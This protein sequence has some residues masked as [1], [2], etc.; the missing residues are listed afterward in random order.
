MLLPLLKSMDIPVVCHVHDPPPSAPFYKSLYRTIDSLTDFFITISESVSV[1]TSELGIR[2]EKIQMLYNGIDL[3]AFPFV[4][5]RSAIFQEQYDWPFDS[6]VIGITGQILEHK[7]HGDLV[8]AVH[9]ARHNVKLRLVIGGKPDGPYFEKLKK[10]VS[11][12]GLA[13]IV[14]FAGWQPYVADFFA[15]IDIFVLASRHEE[16][17]GL[18][19]AE[20]MATGRPV[21]ATASGGSREVVV[22]QE[23]GLSIEKGSPAELAKAILSLATSIDRRQRMGANGR[24]RV[25]RHFD[26]S[27]Q[28]RR[29]E[30]NLNEVGYSSGKKKH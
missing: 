7:G 3:T 22:D 28:G 20:A 6:V 29:F 14:R 15:G 1:R 17:F 30:R 23:T 8:E 5:T 21:I 24:R 12:Y 10:Q 19:V 4:S 26:I 11:D 16:G 2:P 18:V 27:K 25:E 13:K 9:L